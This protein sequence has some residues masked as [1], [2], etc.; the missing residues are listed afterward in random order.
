MRTR[1]ICSV[2]NEAVLK[3]LFKIKDDELSYARAIQ[4]AME[5]ED[6]AKVAKETVHGI[7]PRL[8]NKLQHEPRSSP[9]VSSGGHSTN[10]GPRYTRAFPQVVCV[11]CG[12]SNQISKV[13]P[14][15]T[16][17][18]HFC[19]RKGHLQSVCLQKKRGNKPAIKTI[20][21]Q[22]LQT[23]KRQGEIPE[24]LQPISLNGK[25]FDFEIDTGAGDNFCSGDVWVKLGKPCLQQPTSQ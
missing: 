15:L 11:R 14:Y 22:R 18:C 16:A 10:H 23:V 19:Q 8:V 5:T 13:C 24:L 6:A 2:N 21:K 20:Y 1:F 12:R 4:V 25:K 17:T 7:Q 3:A 9:P